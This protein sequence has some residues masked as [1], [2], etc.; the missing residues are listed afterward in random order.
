M[1]ENH[2]VIELIPAGIG[3]TIF[4]LTN[5]IPALQPYHRVLIGGVVLFF[6]ALELR[7][8]IF[9]RNCGLYLL[10]C[11]LYLNTGVVEDGYWLFFV[12]G[13]LALLFSTLYDRMSDFG[14]W[15][16]SKLS[17][18]RYQGNWLSWLSKLIS[19][20]I[21][22]AIFLTVL[23]VIR[24]VRYYFI[25]ARFTDVIITAA[26]GGGLL[27]VLSLPF[28]QFAWLTEGIYT[29]FSILY[30]SVILLSLAPSLD[31]I[32]AGLDPFNVDEKSV[33]LNLV[34]DWLNL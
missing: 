27:T 28:V 4:M 16:D 13:A 31:M 15:M 34:K 11:G 6:I 14:G 32:S 25:G 19:T 1:S 7:K 30:V 29:I 23:F 10:I 24:E 18:P 12:A 9:T 26:V 33:T 8:A 22:S 20:A 5:I 21:I 3:F 2:G 17:N